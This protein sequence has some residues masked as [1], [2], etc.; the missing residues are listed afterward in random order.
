M[1]ETDVVRTRSGGTAKVKVD[2]RTRSFG[3]RDVGRAVGRKGATSGTQQA[4][5]F[6]VRCGSCNP[7]AG[8]R[9]GMSADVD[10]LS[11]EKDS[12]LVVPIQA[13]SA[14][15]EHVIRSW[16]DR[17]SDPSG[18]KSR[19]KAKPKDAVD[20]SDTTRTGS[21][22]K[23]I[24]GVFLER[25]GKARFVPV[26]MGLRGDTQAEVSGE[27]QPGDRVVTGPYRTLRK[28]QG[29]GCHQADEGEQES[30]QGSSAVDRT[31]NEPLLPPILME[32]DRSKIYEVGQ[33]IRPRVARRRSGRSTK[34]SIVAIMGPSGSG[35]STL[36]N[37]LG[38]LDTPSAGTYRWPAGRCRH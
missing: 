23:M 19:A 5:N 28:S 22:E 35:K 7:P 16:M 6:K 31:R 36:M 20:D 18:K 33:E 37:L 14:Q 2:A 24:E 29:R 15:P 34:G 32:E 26:R 9:P 11:G 13:L 1:D 38:C 8:L 21:N 12:A 25:Q 3:H 17:R 30:G 4:T 27:I 10:L